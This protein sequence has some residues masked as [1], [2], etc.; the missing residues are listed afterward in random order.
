MPTWGKALSTDG[1]SA[2]LIIGVALSLGWCAPRGRWSSRSGGLLSIAGIARWPRCCIVAPI[3]RLLFLIFMPRCQAIRGSTS[4]SRS[5]ASRCLRELFGAS[6]SWILLWLV[7]SWGWS[8]FTWT[9]WAPFTHFRVLFW[10]LMCGF[11][12]S[13]STRFFTCLNTAR[14]WV[15]SAVSRFGLR[16]IFWAL[17]GLLRSWSARV[18]SDSSFPFGTATGTPPRTPTSAYTVFRHRTFHNRSY[19]VPPTV[20]YF[21][22]TIDVLSALMIR[23]LASGSHSPCRGIARVPLCTCFLFGIGRRRM[24]CRCWFGPWV[25]RSLFGRCSVGRRKMWWFGA[26]MVCPVL[27]ACSLFLRRSFRGC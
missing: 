25:L 21:G 10:A 15:T 20:V 12:G 22:L 6:L 4:P 19:R 9:L 14:F 26:R 17:I 1:A 16:T 5:S 3:E 2:G 11:R 27:M 18:R 24:G 8:C 23:I 13:W 7:S